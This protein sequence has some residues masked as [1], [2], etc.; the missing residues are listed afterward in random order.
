MAGKRKRTPSANEKSGREAGSGSSKSRARNN[1]APRAASSSRSTP[2][3]GFETSGHGNLAQQSVVRFSAHD[4]RVI[5]VS[6]ADFDALRAGGFIP[7]SI[8]DIQM[9]SIFDSVNLPD[10]NLIVF[11][12]SSFSDTLLEEKWD[13]AL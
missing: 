1:R 12:E 3:A 4:R 13:D 8:V 5:T 7:P 9:H 10:R 2:E 6:E 11:F